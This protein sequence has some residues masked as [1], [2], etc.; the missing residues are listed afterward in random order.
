MINDG[1]I[2]NAAF[3]TSVVRCS[4]FV[5]RASHVLAGQLVSA[6]SGGAARQSSYLQSMAAASPAKLSDGQDSS[7]IDADGQSELFDDDV[8][9]C[10]VCG[11]THEETMGRRRRLYTQNH[12]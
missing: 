9:P 1:S 3:S 12:S 7:E 2:A 6:T 5:A 4:F 8:G 11:R 10:E